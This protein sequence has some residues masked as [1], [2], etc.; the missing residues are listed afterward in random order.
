M[1]MVGRKTPSFQVLKKSVI[2]GASGV[3]IGV[4]ASQIMDN[5]NS[6]PNIL[7]VLDDSQNSTSTTTQPPP[8]TERVT[9]TTT[10][11]RSPMWQAITSTHAP[12]SLPM[13]MAMPNPSAPTI[14]DRGQCPLVYCTPAPQTPPPSRRRQPQPQPQLPPYIIK[15][16]R[17]YT[18]GSPPAYYDIRKKTYSTSPPPLL[19]QPEQ[20]QSWPMPPPSPPPQSLPPPPLPP[21]TRPPYQT[22]PAPPQSLPPPPPPRSPSPFRNP[23]DNNNNKIGN[24]RIP[25]SLDTLIANFADWSVKNGKEA[26]LN[27]EL[28]KIEDYLNQNNTDPGKKLIFIYFSSSWIPL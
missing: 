17:G 1:S 23:A 21:R 11:T 8:P 18:P 27:A 6:E 15:Y 4:V 19:S 28:D 20:S 14:P 16:S 12:P 3:G 10:T 22:W 9:A 7:V 25:R 2:V 26:V 13:P 5:S 24:S